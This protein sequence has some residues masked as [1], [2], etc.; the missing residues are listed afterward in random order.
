MT[1]TI[2]NR[3]GDR[4]LPPSPGQTV[5]RIG[6]CSGGTV[7][8][9]LAFDPGQER[10]VPDVCGY[11]PLTIGTTRSLVLDG[12]V[13]CLAVKAAASV[14][15]VISSV[16]KTG[17]G[18]SI[19]VAALAL[20]SSG[21]WVDLAVKVTITE[22]GALGVA[23]ANVALDNV[24]TAY[25]IDI[26][27]EKPATLRGSV[28][29]TTITLGD[30][31]TKTFDMGDIDGVNPAAIT[32]SSV[33]TVAAAVTQVDA[34]VGLAAALVGGKYL[35][36]SGAAV[37]ASGS[38]AVAN[39]TANAL[40]G[41]TN[42]QEA[43]GT[44][45]TFI[46]PGTGVEIAFPSGTYV[47]DTTY[48]FI[49]TAPR[50]SLADFDAACVALRESGEPFSIVV[51]MQATIDGVDLVGWQAKLELIVGGWHK[52]TE[53]PIYP[54]WL[55]ASPLGGT[56][57][58]AIQTND[59]DVRDE[60]NGRKAI[61][62]AVVHGDIYLS[63]LEYTGLHRYS[64]VYTAAERC[65]I[66]RLSEDL[67]F[68]GAGDLQNSFLRGPSGTKVRTEA[69][70]VV[71]M[72]ERGFIVIKDEGGAPRFVRGRTRYETGSN[73]V[74]LGV[75]RAVFEADRIVRELLAQQENSDPPTAPDGQLET[76]FKQGLISAFDGALKTGLVNENHFSAAFT[77][78]IVLLP[79]A[80]T[81]K[82]RVTYTLQRKAQ[83]E[84][85]E[86]NLVIVRTI[87]G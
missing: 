20:P 19:T 42:L 28:D 18:P 65:A 78:D 77:T 37:G 24:T 74:S 59:E 3:E 56:G 1:I 55:L 45:S 83:I 35:E 6:V 40:L 44:L 25:S 12:A 21:P 48:T 70:A 82:M 84:D 60:M 4:G 68:G 23:R 39:G 7:G 80:G 30:L 46:I 85:I 34:T 69:R 53:N 26:L 57:S 66:R 43:D 63:T 51:P 50:M 17:N 61:Y 72:K 38:L 58:S 64:A 75:L 33:T 79:N 27:T 49:L 22:G 52:A 5:A 2:Q 71:K 81:D 13:R 73:L 36:I 54:A 31:D 62:G 15:G 76:A 32:F 10:Q 29:L 87:G 11:G 86:G 8:A 9:V 67:G 16:T 41:F 14:P 47:K